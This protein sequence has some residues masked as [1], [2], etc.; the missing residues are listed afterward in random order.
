MPAFRRKSTLKIGQSLAS[1]NPLRRQK[2]LPDYL[3][4]YHHEDCLKWFHIELTRQQ[5]ANLTGMRVETLNRTLIRME[6]AD[7]IIIKDRKILY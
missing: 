1:E 5:I 7:S 2:G 3:K 6:K 4:S